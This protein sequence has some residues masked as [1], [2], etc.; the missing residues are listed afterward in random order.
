MT[1]SEAA[2]AGVMS[3]AIVRSGPSGSMV[4]GAWAIAVEAPVAITIND[5]PWTVMLATPVDLEDLA[6]GLAITERV[7]SHATVIADVRIS[8]ALGEYTVQLSADSA[9]VD[10]N[11][12]RARSLL[13]NTACGLCGIE[14]LAALH[15]RHTERHIT[16][17]VDD[18]AIRRAAGTLAAHQ[19][20]N[21]TTRSVHAAAWCTMQG[22]IVLARED[23]GRHNALDKLVGAVRRSGTPVTPGFVLMSSRC[24][25]ELVYK[26]IALDAQLLATVSA[27]TTMALQWAEQLGLPLV[28]T[29]GRGDVLEIIRF[30]ESGERGN[31]SHAQE[32]VM[33]HV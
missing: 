18:K 23:V 5:T 6:I 33:H 31:M 10:T 32:P 1:D 20:L 25:Y 4:A 21:A 30:P 3:R 12:L 22:D 16:E 26:A 2:T 17:P 13:G 24:S 11:A 8:E 15:S 29:M 14:T 19:P 27:P 9:L 28:S 7:V